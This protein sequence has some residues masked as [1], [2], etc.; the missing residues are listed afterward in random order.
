MGNYIVILF[1]SGIILLGAVRRVNVFDTFIEGAR[2]GMRTAA[3]IMPALTA[4]TFC[5]SAF[6]SSGAVGALGQALSPALAALHIPDGTVGMMLIRPLSGSGAI[7]VLEDIFAS[8]GPDS[9]TGLV[10]SVM[11]GS[12]E[13]TFYTMALYFGGVGIKKTGCALPAALSADLTGMIFAA[14]SVRLLMQ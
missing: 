8:S 5:I 2:D 7:A 4:L 1:V 11:M 10:A 14:L 12:T 9:D 3:G 13:T 6:R